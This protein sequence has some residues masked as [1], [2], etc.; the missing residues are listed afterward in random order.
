MCIQGNYIE[1]TKECAASVKKKKKKQAADK[2][3]P[4]RGI[5]VAQAD[6][7]SQTAHSCGVDVPL[8]TPESPVS[9]SFSSWGP[10][11]LPLNI[12]LYFHNGKMKSKGNSGYREWRN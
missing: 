4:K 8:S 3:L 2:N 12:F 1:L 6:N 11:L 7:Y 5:K 10:F 9:I